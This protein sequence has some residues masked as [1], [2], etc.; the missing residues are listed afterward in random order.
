MQEKAPARSGP[1]AKDTFGPRVPALADASRPPTPAHPEAP[2]GLFGGLLDRFAEIV[3]DGPSY[4][5]FHFASQQEG[6]RLAAGATARD[7]PDLL[8]RVDSILGHHSRL[9]EASP[10][11]VRI[12]VTGSPLVRSR[13][14]IGI[15]LGLLEGLLKA[16]YKRSFVGTLEAAAAAEGT[17]RLRFDGKVM[18]A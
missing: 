5:T 15:I 12:D 10:D 9:G 16:A 1:T 18:G 11:C 3:G 2:M 17:A 14:G 7:V 4:A 13:V 6:A 8:Q